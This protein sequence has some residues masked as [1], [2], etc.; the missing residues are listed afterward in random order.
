MTC[1]IAFSGQGPSGISGHSGTS[2]S[3]GHSGSSGSSGH[4]GSSG[5]SGHSGDSGYSGSTGHSGSSG[6]PG[7]PNHSALVS[8]PVVLLYSSST[9]G[10]SPFF[11]GTYLKNKNLWLSFFPA[12]NA[13]PFTF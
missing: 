3:S 8:L 1:I 2:G 10:S 11:G 12:K 6:Q 5:S 7:G 9:K 13:P 4:S